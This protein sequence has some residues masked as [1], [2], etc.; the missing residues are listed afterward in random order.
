MSRS[1][2]IVQMTRARLG[3][4]TIMR[5]PA[6]PI[7]ADGARQLMLLEQQ[8]AITPEEGRT[9]FD[10]IVRALRSEVGAWKSPKERRKTG[11]A[12]ERASQRQLDLLD[13]TLLL[14]EAEHALGRRSDESLAEVRDAVRRDKTAILAMLRGFSLGDD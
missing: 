5:Q 10:Q 13:G 2:P 8:G 6:G 7:V 1:A 11:Q 14:A 12:L 4:A 9:A 3:A